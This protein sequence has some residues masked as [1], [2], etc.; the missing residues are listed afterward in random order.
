M[1]VNR[2]LTLV[3]IIVV[4]AAAFGTLSAQEEVSPEAEYARVRSLALAGKY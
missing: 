2:C 4:S 1:H 3:F